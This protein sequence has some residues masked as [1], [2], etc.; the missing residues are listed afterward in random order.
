MVENM[1][2]TIKFIIIGLAIVII[3]YTIVKKL[4]KNSKKTSCYWD[5]LDNFDP[6]NPSWF[7]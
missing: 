3:I 2:K 6:L 5:V 7:E 4:I 1:K